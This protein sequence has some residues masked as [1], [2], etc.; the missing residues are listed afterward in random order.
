MEYG[1]TLE[2][3]YMV[4]Y[5]DALLQSHYCLN[6]SSAR[7]NPPAAERMAGKLKFYHT[8]HHISIGNM[9]PYIKGGCLF[10]VVICSHVP[11]TATPTLYGYRLCIL[12]FQIHI[13]T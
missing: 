6:I 4:V 7:N 1:L 8:S 11:V 13:C 10:S 5:K 2:I 12:H 3:L 9:K